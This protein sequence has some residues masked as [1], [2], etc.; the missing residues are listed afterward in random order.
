MCRYSFVRMPGQ[1]PI[2]VQEG[3]EAEAAEIIAVSSFRTSYIGTALILRV[4]VRTLVMP[5]SFR[6]RTRARWSS[7]WREPGVDRMRMV[8]GCVG[9]LGSLGSWSR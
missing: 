4:S 1:P 5:S 3:R 2:P 9:L 8:W 6:C 7:S